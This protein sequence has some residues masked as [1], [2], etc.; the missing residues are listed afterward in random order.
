[1]EGLHICVRMTDGISFSLSSHCHGNKGLIEGAGAPTLGQG[2]RQRELEREHKGEGSERGTKRGQAVTTQEL[3]SLVLQTSQLTW[4]RST[5]WTRPEAS[6]RW[7]SLLPNPRALAANRRCGWA[8]GW[9]SRVASAAGW[10]RTRL[11]GFLLPTATTSSRAAASCCHHIASDLR[12]L[13]NDQRDNKTEI[14]PW[15]YRGVKM[16]GGVSLLSDAGG[17]W[18][19][20]LVCNISTTFT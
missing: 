2:D 4:W 17:L 12:Y 9:R 10:R 18:K 5:R 3:V 7:C 11:P 20:T 8:R 15:I 1:M 13:P 6:Y 16:W 19:Q 14:D